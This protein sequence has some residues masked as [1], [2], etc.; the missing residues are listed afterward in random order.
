[1]A[2]NPEAERPLPARRRALLAP[3]A[4][5][6]LASTAAH[7]GLGE[8]A[9]SVA[10]NHLALGGRTLTVIPAVAYDIHETTTADGARVRQYVSRGG[11]VFAV[12]WSGRT[13]PDLKILLAQHYDQYLAAAS[14]HRGGHH[15]FT[16]ATPELAVTIV[17]APRAFEGAAHVP[18]LVPAGTSTSEFR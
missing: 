3:L 18:A 15:L 13:M 8:R 14:A 5:A 7:A 16:V 4:L 10:S 12:A 1:M 9:D 17:R 2:K 11:T 6:A